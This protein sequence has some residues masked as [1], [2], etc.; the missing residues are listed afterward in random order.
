VTDPTLA[1]TIRDYAFDHLL[2]LTI[3]G[4]GMKS[5]R[6]APITTIQ[7]E[8]LPA[9]CVFIH[10]ENEDQLG[11]ARGVTLPQFEATLEIGISWV[12]MA[13]DEI[14]IDGTLDAFVYLAKS[15]LLGD[16]NFIGLYEYTTGVRRQYNY[17]KVGES[18]IAE[19]RVILQV[20]YKTV[21]PPLAPYDLTLID[22]KTVP[23][24]GAAVI[25]TQIPIVTGEKI[26]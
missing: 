13:A 21:Y 4:R 9:L 6:K 24:S 19:I 8:Q 26:D 12:V 2:P 3:N 25:E 5:A 22:I 14:L 20:T 11:G 7:P 16:P 23:V 15:T 1:I 10:N 17:S 18:Y